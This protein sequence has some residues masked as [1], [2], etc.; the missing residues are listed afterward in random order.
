MLERKKSMVDQSRRKL[1]VNPILFVSIFISLLIL[2]QCSFITQSS[3][4]TLDEGFTT[5]ILHKVLLSENDDSTQYDNVT[6]NAIDIDDDFLINGAEFS[7]FD[8]TPLILDGKTEKD[9][10]DMNN[11]FGADAFKDYFVEK[12]VTGEDSG[13]GI[14]TFD[15]L[16]GSHNSSAKY[17]ILE[18]KRPVVTKM[19]IAQP[20]YLE[21]PL[22]QQTVNIYPKNYEYVRDPYFYKHGQTAEGKDT[23]ALAGAKFRLY[24]LDDNGNKLYLHEDLV[25][26]NNK[27]VNVDDPGVTVIISDKNGLVTTGEHY[28]PIGEFYF[29]EVTAPDGYNIIDEAEKVKVTVPEDNNEPVTITVNNKTTTMDKSI[30]FNTA[31]PEKLISSLSPK[32]GDVMNIILY[33]GLLVGA[34]IVISVL[35]GLRIKKAHDEVF[36]GRVAPHRQ[37]S[38]TSAK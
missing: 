28:L 23:G 5:V 18:T 9:L 16:N 13:K 7:V 24:K 37:N 26:N 6:G 35:I 32:T 14:V 1:G 10:L 4:E 21:V 19:E 11:T 30:V 17:L 20:I 22:Q 33:V 15:L 34:I 38:P 12:N 29:E 27:W 25:D 31:N 2:I 3:A 8:V 36:N